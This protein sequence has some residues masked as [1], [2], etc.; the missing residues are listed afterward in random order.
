MR[1]LHARGESSRR[2]PGAPQLSS[3]AIQNPLAP[4]ANYHL[5]PASSLCRSRTLCSDDYHR[6][7]AHR[8]RQLSFTTRV[9]TATSRV[10]LSLRGHE[11]G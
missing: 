1:P 2:L 6:M 11:A 10:L 4:A 5:I 9:A 3:A 7:C 8:F